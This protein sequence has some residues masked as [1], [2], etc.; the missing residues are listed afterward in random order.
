ML[1][2]AERGELEQRARR[3]KSSHGARRGVRRSTS[4]VEA[5]IER[6][7]EAHN[8]NPKPFRW[9]KS[10]DDILTT[11]ERFCHRTLKVHAKVG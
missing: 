2:D 9:T 11:V 5:A 10:A 1:S 7:I 8:R 4:Q 3:R 6:Y